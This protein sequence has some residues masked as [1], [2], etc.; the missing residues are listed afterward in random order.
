ML[1]CVARVLDAAAGW[2]QSLV[3]DAG[4]RELLF[5]LATAIA[6][7]AGTKAVAR[8]E[9]VRANLLRRWAET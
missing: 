2:I 1:P 8:L 4:R 7:A 9:L 6:E 5:E 3:R